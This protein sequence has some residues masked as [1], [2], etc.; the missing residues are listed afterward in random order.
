MYL[1][2]HSCELQIYEHFLYCFFSFTVI[3]QMIGVVIFG[4]EIEDAEI[5]TEGA[6]KVDWCFILVCVA[7]GVSFV[8]LTLAVVQALRMPQGGKGATRFENGPDLSPVE[9]ATGFENPNLQVQISLDN[10]KSES[11]S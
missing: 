4:H 11:G 2:C 9:N 1:K 8:P 3:F 6:M 7:L 5:E 10:T